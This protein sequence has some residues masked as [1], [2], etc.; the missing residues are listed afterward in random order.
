MFNVQSVAGR[1]LTVGHFTQAPC[2]TKRDN[3]A[4][5]FLYYFLLCLCKCVK[6][7]FL[8]CLTTVSVEKRVQRYGEFLIPA[9]FLANIFQQ[10]CTFYVF[11]DDY[12]A[13][14]KKMGVI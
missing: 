10:R 9:N 12:Q 5:C 4:L 11:L 13:K 6:E 7:L 2:P 14:S 1:I 3:G 8:L